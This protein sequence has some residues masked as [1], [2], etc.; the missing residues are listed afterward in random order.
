MQKQLDNSASLSSNRQVTQA[1][2]F[3]TISSYTTCSCWLI[4]SVY[5]LTKSYSIFWAKVI[6]GCLIKIVPEIQ[7][8]EIRILS[9]YFFWKLRTSLMW[10]WHIQM[11][12]ASQHQCKCNI[13]NNKISDTE[14]WLHFDFFA[15]TRPEHAKLFHTMLVITLHYYFPPGSKNGN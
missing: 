4:V 15:S 3:L 10:R 5:E 6:A 2:S 13:N 12:T 11:D 14:R 8:P 7:R 9:S 1:A